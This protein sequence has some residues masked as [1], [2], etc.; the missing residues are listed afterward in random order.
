MP[1]CLLGALDA[2]LRTLDGNGGGVLGVD[3]AYEIRAGA[4]GCEILSLALRDGSR[5]TVALYVD[6]GGGGRT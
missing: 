1:L 3:V 4:L 6:L 2:H 5:R